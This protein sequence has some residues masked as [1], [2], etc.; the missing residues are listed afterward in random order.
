MGPDNS[1]YEGGVFFIEITFPA[2]I[3]ARNIISSSDR[4]SI[5]A[6]KGDFPDQ[7]LP[8]QHQRQG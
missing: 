4:L 1:P 5:Q 7:D 6:T 8:L 2:G 3:I